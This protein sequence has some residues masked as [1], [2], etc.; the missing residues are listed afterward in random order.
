MD[1]LSK[2]TNKGVKT[3]IWEQLLCENRYGIIFINVAIYLTIGGLRD[4]YRYI[5]YCNM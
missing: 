1:I 4:G 5:Q 3:V 2:R